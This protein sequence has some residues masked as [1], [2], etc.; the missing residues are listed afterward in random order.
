MNAYT[1]TKCRKVVQI[2]PT[3]VAQRKRN[4]AR[5]VCRSC[6]V[7]ERGAVPP[8]ATPQ[9]RAKAA[10]TRTKWA[11]NKEQTRLVDRANYAA[12]LLH[13]GR[14][15]SKKHGFVNYTKSALL[16]CTREEFLHHLNSLKEP[17]MTDENYGSMWELDHILPLRQA[18]L[19]G[20]DAYRSACHYSNIRPVYRM[21][22][23]H[24]RNAFVVS[25]FTR[26]DC[27]EHSTE[28]GV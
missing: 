28:L 18:V 23:L 27:N 21:Q 24:R 26:A 19:L 14:A 2:S 16:G 17:W 11:L 22:N 20:E 9:S 3:N 7:L 8:K 13:R 1:C 10:K 6:I 25:L 4:N 15:P 5:D 12:A